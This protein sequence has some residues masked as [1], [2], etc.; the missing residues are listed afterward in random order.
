MRKKEIK[1][2]EGKTEGKVCDSILIPLIPPV[3]RM[4]LLP[5][6]PASSTNVLSKRIEQE[7]GSEN[8]DQLQMERQQEGQDREPVPMRA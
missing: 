4:V 7:E 3:L 5:S 6:L 8:R 2:E 1:G